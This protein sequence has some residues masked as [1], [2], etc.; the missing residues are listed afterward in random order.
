[1]NILVL[2]KTYPNPE[3][4][5]LDGTTPVVR[6]FATSWAAA[7]HVV[8][9]YQNY[10]KKPKLLNTL[11]AKAIEMLNSKFGYSLTPSK[12][13]SSKNGNLIRI[14]DGVRVARFPLLKLIPGRGLAG[15]QVMRQFRRIKKDLDDE[16][17]TPDIIVAHWE[18]PQLQLLSMLK[19]VFGVPC[20]FTCHKI[21]YLN[22]PGYLN[23]A[24]NWLTDVDALFVRSEAISEQL[25]RLLGLDRPLPVCRSGISPIFFEK[26]VQKGIR[27]R[28][29]LYVGRLLPYKNI[30]V[31][32]KACQS[33]KLK[34]LGSLRIVGNG[35]EEDVLR[36]IEANNVEFLGKRNHSFV[37]DELD[38]AS[39]L[40]MVSTNETFGLSYIEAM[41]RGCIVIAGDDGGMCGVIK[42]GENGFLCPPGNVLELQNLLERIDRLNSEEDERIR[43]NAIETASRFTQAKCAKSYLDTA[44]A[45]AATG[46]KERLR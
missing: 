21:A 26:P 42:N 9:V 7:G 39:V 33:P 44:L 17:F 43:T 5:E 13:N 10:T 18:D 41:A 16:R 37:V 3:D 15:V 25:Q 32:I 2:T 40:A 4:G 36:R 38:R 6:D 31:L 20:V 11:P 46:K 14:E 8:Y 19:S 23:K 28:G 12:V 1:M 34:L 35:P 27:R 24:R 45:I 22:R 30:D 29:V